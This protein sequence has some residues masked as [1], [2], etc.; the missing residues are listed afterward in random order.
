M[1]YELFELFV[2]ELFDNKFLE[3]ET[4]NLFIHTLAIIYIFHANQKKK[5]FSEKGQPPDIK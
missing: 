3:N 1:S 2:T 5:F 4:N